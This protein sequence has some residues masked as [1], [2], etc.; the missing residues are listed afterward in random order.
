MPHFLLVGAGFTRNWGG[1]LSD[2]LTG[3]L[4]GDLHDDPDLARVLRKGPFEEAFQGFQRPAS[5]SQR[6]FQD[7][8][9]NVFTRLN[10]T[11]LEVT[12]EFSQY[13]EFSVKGFL[14]KFD[15][16][17]SLNQDLLL[18]IHYR[19]NFTQ[20]GKWSGV[21]VPGM[22]AR[23]LEGQDHYGAFA[24]YWVPTG[25]FDLPRNMQPFV[26]LHG[27]TNWH[28][29]A[30]EKMLI[31]GNAKTGAIQKFDVLGRYHDFFASSLKQPNAKLMV[32]GYSFQD[33]HINKVI[34][35]ASDRHGLGTYLVDLRGRDV[36]PD[37]KM[38]NAQIKAPR[39]LEGIKLIG[40]LRRP[41]STVFSG[42]K[43]AHQELMRFFR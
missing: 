4:L 19:P 39:A 17:F 34:V 5:D 41:L 14:A 10:K 26:K 25:T 43:F 38:A 15:A 12:F 13:V 24:E 33:E 9:T 2:E 21:V 29:T 3:S 6:R 8:V 23:A 36:L 42:D 1:P 11:L 20:A 18:E 27:S 31:M 16:I 30:H 32:I 37:P 22:Q 7:A 40:E 28:T 35:E